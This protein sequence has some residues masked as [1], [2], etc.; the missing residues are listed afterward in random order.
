MTLVLAG[1]LLAAI[2]WRYS[3]DLRAASTPL[4][5]E[6][7]STA[8]ASPFTPSRADGSE[9]I[10]R[11]VAPRPQPTPMF[12]SYGS[13]KIRLPVPIGRLTEVGFHQAAYP[14]ALHMKTPL[15][16]ADNSDTAARK[17]TGRDI[18]KQPSGVD[19]PL[20]GYMIRMWRN[21]PGKPDTAADIGAKPGTKV[22][23]PVSGT[24]IKIKSYKL[25]GKY[26]DY[27]LHIKPDDTTGLDLVMIHLTD[28]TSKVGDHVDGGITP[29]AHVRKLS[30]KI[31]DQLAEYT[32]GGGDHVHLALNNC[33]YKGYK[34]LIGA[35]SVNSSGAA[36]G[37]SGSGAATG[38][39]ES[40]G[41]GDYTSGD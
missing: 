4:F 40:D 17:S 13:L 12:A 31:R 32:T 34:G 33:N 29:I 25:Y 16:E 14:Y 11:F 35:I 26:P 18:S 1:L 30:D 2:G 20:I 21:R 15:K 19:V 37:G 24:I 27:E 39:T 38:S 9:R 36:T 41:E 6:T 7:T 23:A 3:S 10:P 22:L 28:L 8:S 5:A